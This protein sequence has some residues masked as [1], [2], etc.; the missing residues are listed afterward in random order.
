MTTCENFR[1]CEEVLARNR[2]VCCAESIACFKTRS[3][4]AKSAYKKN[5]EDANHSTPNLP[6]QITAAAGS[7]SRTCM[8]FLPCNHTIKHAV[9]PRVRS[10]DRLW[11][12][13]WQHSF[14]ARLI[15]LNG[16]RSRCCR[17]ESDQCAAWIGMLL[18]SLQAWRWKHSTRFL[19]LFG[20]MFL[21]S[22]SAASP[23]L[24]TSSVRRRGAS[25][26]DRS[27][28]KYCILFS[29][30]QVFRNSLKVDGDKGSSYF[31]YPVFFV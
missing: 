23:V 4:H 19:N 31:I 17:D 28:A 21:V 9:N 10:P 5:P 11:R 22:A 24:F 30:P 27:L 12:Y 16:T 25:T 14:Q 7:C 29:E 2:K 8:G 18:N 26:I 15:R 6:L 3:K 1:P 13:F 20:R